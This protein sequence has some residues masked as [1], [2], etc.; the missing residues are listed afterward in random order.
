MS[1]AD[2]LKTEIESLPP[3]EF[4]ELV[5]WLSE[6]DWE[7]WDKQIETDSA[8]GR[9]DFLVDEALEAKAKGTLENL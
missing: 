5:R 9:L 6:K 8:A 4:A 7:R 3:E 2:E 1:K